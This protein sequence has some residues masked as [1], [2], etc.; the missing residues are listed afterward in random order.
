M[1]TVIILFGL[2]VAA[3]AIPLQSHDRVFREEIVL[4]RKPFHIPSS[5]RIWLP[6]TIKSIRRSF[7]RPALRQDS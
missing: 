4:L 1:K 7:N 2:L 5:L 6:H 3:N